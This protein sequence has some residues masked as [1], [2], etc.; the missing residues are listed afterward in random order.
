MVRLTPAHARPTFSKLGRAA[1]QTDGRRERGGE[2][3]GG[4]RGKG[5]SAILDLT[6]LGNF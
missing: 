4:G 3:R 6:K 5:I 1:H 2:E